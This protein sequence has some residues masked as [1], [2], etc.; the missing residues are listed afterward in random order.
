MRKIACLCTMLM[1]FCSIA[2]AQS[3]TITGTVKDNTGVPVPFATVKIK[4]SRVAIS[5]DENGLFRINAPVNSVLE[6]S[7]VG[8]ET[9]TV[10]T[11]GLGG[12]INVTLIRTTELTAV[13]VTTSPGIGRYSK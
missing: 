7:A 2:F 13:I 12:V 8:S 6:I 1:L 4:G 10:P 5:A 9:K 11:E 3:K